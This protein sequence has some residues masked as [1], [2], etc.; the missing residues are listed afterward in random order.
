MSSTTSDMRVGMKRTHLS[1][2]TSPDC[3]ASPIY[4]AGAAVEVFFRSCHT[5]DG[6]FPVTSYA[7]ALLRPRVGLTDG[8]V[9]AR[10]LADWPPSAETSHA[11]PIHVCYTH[12]C[13]SN[14]H[15]QIL[16]PAEQKAA[17][18]AMEA[19][20]AGASDA[21][22]L[23]SVA[24]C[25]GLHAPADVRPAGAAPGEGAGS[26]E[27]AGSGEASG[28]GVHHPPPVLSV[29][30]V[31]W[32]GGATAFNTAQWGA[33]SASV[34]DTYID[35]FTN[36]VLYAALG[37]AYEVQSVFVERGDD[38]DRL[39]PAA[40][41]PLLRGRHKC[42]CFFLWP[43]MVTD[44]AVQ[45]MGMLHAAAALQA[46]RRV[47]AA[48]VRTVFPHPSPLYQLLLSKD[49]QLGRK[50]P[51]AHRPTLPAWCLPRLRPPPPGSER[52][53]SR[54]EARGGRRSSP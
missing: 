3:G 33:T 45:Q 10:V 43:T 44:G 28:A 6:S 42:A 9:S 51:S 19:A 20:A 32:G 41:L 50:A 39:Q 27:R 2:R 21:A 37:P 49:W 54:L 18:A 16:E 14:R 24:M 29:V 17:R 30:A 38:L 12:P 13:W 23:A 1:G 35:Y 4:P 7:A 5:P 52:S 8:W 53:H 25:D 11:Q 36:A 34:S 15:G 31:R 40:L 48:G 46:M 47:E 26:G 22:A